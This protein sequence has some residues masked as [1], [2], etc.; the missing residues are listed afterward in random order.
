MAPLQLNKS[1]SKWAHLEDKVLSCSHFADLETEGR[2]LTR[3][4]RAGKQDHQGPWGLCSEPP[5]HGPHPG[6]SLTEPSL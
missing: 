5:L 4:H 3:G 2:K 1:S 6:V